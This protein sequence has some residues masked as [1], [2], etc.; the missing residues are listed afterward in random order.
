MLAN[1]LELPFRSDAIEKILKDT[2]RR[3]KRP[4]LQNLGG[5]TSIMGLHTTMTS[6]NAVNANRLPAPSLI[7]WHESFAI[8]QKSHSDVLEIFSPSEGKIT[9]LYFSYET[10]PSASILCIIPVTLA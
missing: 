7:V 4:T 1:E 9:P 5:I 10:R 2:I 8:V 3:G 6:I